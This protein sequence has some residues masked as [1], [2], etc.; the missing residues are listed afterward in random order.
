M[1]DG[2]SQKWRPSAEKSS[3]G[4]AENR[5]S[6]IQSASMTRCIVVRPLTTRPANTAHDRYESSR[7]ALRTTIRTV[8]IMLAS[9]SAACWTARPRASAGRRLSS[10]S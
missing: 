5:G 10:G 1:N 7:P 8:T 4:H 3:P 9:D 6:P 2:S